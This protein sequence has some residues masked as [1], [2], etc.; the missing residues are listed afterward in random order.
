MGTIAQELSK[1]AFDKKPSKP[2]NSNLII[3]EGLFDS[4]NH[5][6]HYEDGG[7]ETIDFIEVKKLNYHLGNAVK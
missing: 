2:D 6:S 7:I 3:P 5:P 1:R 4:V